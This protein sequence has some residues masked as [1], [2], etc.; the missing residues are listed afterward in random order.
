MPRRVCVVTG[1]RADFGYLVEP[2]R[3][4]AAEPSMRLQTVVSGAHLSSAHGLTYRHV[5]AA[6]FSI[7]AK[8]DMQLGDSELAVA[9][10][11]GIGT[12]GFSEA[13]QRLEPDFVM[14][15]GDRYETLAAATACLLLR[16][17]VVHLAGGDVSEGAVDEQIRHAIT[18]LSHLHFTTHPEAAERVRQMGEDPRAVHCV[19]S[20]SLDV[21][22]AKPRLSAAEA[23]AAAGLRP[24]ARNLV[25]AFHPETLCDE[26]ATAQ[27]ERVL[28]A[29]DA[30]PETGVVIVAANADAQGA[31]IN[32]VLGAYAKDRD[33]VAFQ[34]SFP[35]E[36][37][38][39]LLAHADVLVGNSSSGVY[40]APSLGTP[41]VN[42]GGR[43][44]GRTKAASVIDCPVESGAIV[45]AIRRAFAF[46]MR[47]VENPYGDGRA[48]ER[49]V[50]ILEA[51]HDPRALLHKRFHP[52]EALHAIAA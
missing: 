16:I 43:Q 41:T 47:H 21:I 52:M 12:M 24:R 22:L 30:V 46:D 14:L 38:L 1:S 13:F 20:T 27:L 35:H 40:E 34:A 50:A 18:K 9:K 11:V 49:I 6:G 3:R 45:A 23:F 8:V 19:G 26:P 28:T 10:S 42:L 4:I 32:A 37:Y 39:S 5:E 44:R 36:V 15:L 31:A 29:L 7:D 17:P 48:S 2:M 51:I 25:L 33:H